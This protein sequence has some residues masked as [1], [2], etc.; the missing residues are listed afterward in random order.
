MKRRFSIAAFLIAV[1]M[2]SVAGTASAYFFGGWPETCLEMNDMVEASSRGSG[3]VGIYQRAFGEDAEAACQR[4]HRNDIRRAFAWAIG[5]APSAETISGHLFANTPHGIRYTLEFSSEEPPDITASGDYHGRFFHI[6]C[7]LRGKERELRYYT[8]A[9]DVSGSGIE[10]V[11][12]G[13]NAIEQP[14]EADGFIRSCALLRNAT[15]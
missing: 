12:A 13:F 14:G 15:V 5:E 7:Y 9:P 1:A 8:S 6:R 4:D 2:V 11:R 10:T 3:A